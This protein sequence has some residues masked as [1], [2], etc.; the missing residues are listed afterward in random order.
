MSLFICAVI[1]SVFWFAAEPS[2]EAL[3]AREVLVGKPFDIA[4][5]L[6]GGTGMVWRAKSQKD[7]QVKTV[8]SETPIDGGS[9]CGA[10]KIDDVFD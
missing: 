1:A 9:E 2:A 4:L 5:P 10:R 7:V 8:L 3:A 6:T